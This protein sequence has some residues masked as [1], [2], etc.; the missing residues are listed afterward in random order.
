MVPKDTENT[1]YISFETLA[2]I[3][4]EGNWMSNDA[5]DHFFNDDIY[6]TLLLD[7]DQMNLWLKKWNCDYSNL[8]SILGFPKPGPEVF[9]DKTL[10]SP[11]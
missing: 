5:Y 8:G 1:T 2:G 6:C 10:T 11:T 9:A 3:L 4:R 7:Y